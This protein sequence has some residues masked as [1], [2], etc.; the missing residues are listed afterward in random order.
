MSAPIIALLTDFG[1][2]DPFVGV[3][4][5]VLLTHCPEA[6]IVDL[7]HAVPPQAVG[8]AA[9]WLDRSFRFLPPG[10]LIIAVVDPGVGTDRRALVARAHG[11]IFLAPDNGLLS[12]V[13]SGDALAE[14]YVIDPQRLGLPAPSRT[15]HGRDIFAKVAGEMAAGRLAARDVGPRI[16]EIARSA[17]PEP[18][19]RAGAIEGIVVAVDRFGNLITNIGGEMLPSSGAVVEIGE[20][21]L[22]VC[23]TYSDARPGEI[24]ALVNAFDVIEIA[25]RDGNASVALGLDRG[26]PVVVRPGPG[27][28]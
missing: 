9:F 5:G 11:R 23:G 22:A 17:G 1:T 3:L 18:R 27:R 28:S 13:V 24:L 7:S 4:K 15:F 8:E 19:R 6:S 25:E 26:A 12:K 20:A 14:L 2:Q 10:A 16:D 21:R